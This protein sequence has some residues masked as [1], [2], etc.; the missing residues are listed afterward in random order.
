LAR[1]AYTLLEGQSLQKTIW[2]FLEKLTH[3]DLMSQQPCFL[4]ISK[5]EAKASVIKQGV[6]GCSWLLHS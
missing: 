5:R 1:K 4:G 6:L 3:N 2:Q